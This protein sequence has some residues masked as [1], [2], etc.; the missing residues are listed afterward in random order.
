METDTNLEAEEVLAFNLWWAKNRKQLQ[1]LS[2]RAL[3][4]T[5]WQARAQ[6]EK[7]PN[8]VSKY[9]KLRNM[10]IGLRVDKTNAY[11]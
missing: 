3:A 6:I 5:V 8:P 4:E 10:I 9:S 7:G 2:N 1:H 11:R